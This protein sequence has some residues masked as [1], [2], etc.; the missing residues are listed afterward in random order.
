MDISPDPPTPS[1]SRESD[2][3]S[4]RSLRDRTRSHEQNRILN[5]PSKLPSPPKWN[6]KNLVPIRPL[7]VP[8]PLE[9]SVVKTKVSKGWKFYYK[10]GQPKYWVAPMVHGSE[11][12]FRM[13]VKSLGAHMTATPMIHARKYLEDPNYRHNYVKLGFTPDRPL[14][15]QLAG[16][17]IPVM[18]Q[19]ALMIQPYCDAID[20]NFGCP[21]GIARRG[22]YGA[23]LLEEPQLVFDLVSAMTLNLDIPVFCKIRILDTPSKTIKLAQLLEKAGCAILTVHGRTIDNKGVYTTAADWD[24]LR[25][26]KQSVSMPVIANGNCR[27]LKDAHDCLLYTGCDGIM[28]AT[29]ILRNPALFS[30]K[31]IPIIDLCLQYLEFTSKYYISSIAFKKHLFWMLKL[32]LRARFPYKLNELAKLETSPQNPK[33]C[34]EFIKSLKSFFEQHQIDPLGS[35]R[36]Y[37]YKS[38]QYI[39]TDSDPKTKGSS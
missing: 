10:F 4:S 18:V 33:P 26:V 36:L 16:D 7:P 13:F 12:A 20:I 32:P 24:I 9:E 35:D 23:F 19:S 15:A 14:I 34:V 22:H 38:S 37:D 1:F 3:P 25:L 39:E 6:R 27:D 11:L 21:Q 30:G 31:N 2:L 5:K 28:S 8:F 29:G 17:S